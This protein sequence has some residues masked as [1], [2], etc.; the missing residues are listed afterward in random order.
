MSIM[1]AS[2]SQTGPLGHSPEPASGLGH[3]ASVPCAKGAARARRIYISESEHA[4]LIMASSKHGPIA[5]SFGPSGVWLAPECR[6]P[7]PLL[8]QW[9][10]IA[11]A[12]GAGI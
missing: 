3:S 12:D 8:A 4:L 2:A 11:F 10:G 5:T 7:I 9:R 6:W 1:G